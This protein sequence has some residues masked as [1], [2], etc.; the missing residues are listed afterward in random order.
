MPLARPA[1]PRRAR[2]RRGAGSLPSCRPARPDVKTARDACGSALPS[3]CGACGGETSGRDGPHTCWG[4]AY[5]RA[6]LSAAVDH[7]T[8][9]YWSEAFDRRSLRGPARTMFDTAA[10][11]GVRDGFLQPAPQR[12]GSVR[13][14]SMM[15]SGGAHGGAERQAL[16]LVARAILDGPVALRKASCQPTRALPAR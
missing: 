6:L 1:S 2:V 16:Q 14:V 10:D 8:G 7:P 5:R 3:S 15:G 11:A 12:D 4:G 13:L 9:F